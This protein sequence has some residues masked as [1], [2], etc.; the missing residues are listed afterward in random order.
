LAKFTEQGIYEDVGNP[1]DSLPVNNKTG[2]TNKVKI[3]QYFFIDYILFKNNIITEN[4]NFNKF[5]CNNQL[6]IRSKFFCQNFL[7]FTEQ[8]NL[9]FTKIHTL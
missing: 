9:V 3:Y 1:K 8:I 2:I 5:S 7:L 6:V 4:P